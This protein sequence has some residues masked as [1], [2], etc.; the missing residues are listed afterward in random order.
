MRVSFAVAANALLPVTV[1]LVALM[2]GGVPAWN[3]MTGYF[4]GRVKHS[5]DRT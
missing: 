2:P 5:E 3:S 4:G 1:V